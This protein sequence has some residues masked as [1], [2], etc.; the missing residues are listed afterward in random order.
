M[1]ASL[2]LLQPVEV[3]SRIMDGCVKLDLARKKILT[4][5]SR[6]SIWV[7]SDLGI[8]PIKIRNNDH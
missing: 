4:R 6:I 3:K 1:L 5:R 7:E 2:P 8:P